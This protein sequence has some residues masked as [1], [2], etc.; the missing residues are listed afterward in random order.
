M[1]SYEIDELLKKLTLEEKIGMIHGQGIFHTKGVERL[2]LPPLWTSDGP[3][4]VRKELQDDNWNAKGTTEDFVSYLPSNSA[5]ACT[6]QPELAREMG[7]VLGE[8]ARGRGKDVILAPGINLMRSPLCGRNFEYMS[9]DPCLISKLAPALVQGIQEWD[10]AACVKH[11]AANNQETRRLDVDVQMEER[12]LRELYLPGF[13]ASVKEGKSLSVMGAYNR[14]RG[15]HC[16]HNHYLL[17]EVLRGEWGFDGVVI[18]DWGGVHDT[19][20]AAENGLDIEMSVTDCFDEYYMA[21]PLLEKVKRGELSEKLVDEKVRNILVLMDRL[22]MLDGK[23]KAGAYNTREHQEKLLECAREA[24]VL[25]KNEEN[26]LPLKLKGKKRLAVI[27]ENAVKQHAGGGGSGAIKALYELSPLMGLHM[28]LGGNVKID[29]APGYSSE[30][31]K[32][33]EKENWQSSSLED[34]AYKEAYQESYTKEEEERRAAL[35]QEAVKLAASCEDV[36]LFCGLNHEFDLEGQDRQ[37]LKLPYGQEELIE[38]VLEANPNTILVLISG[39]PVDLEAFA[40]KAKAILYSSYN[41]MEGGRALAEI[42]LGEVNPSGK[43]AFTFPKRLEDCP[44]HKLGEFPGGDQVFYREGV[45]VGY[46]YYETEG[47]PVR[48]CFGHG[49]SYT[50]FEYKDLKIHKKGEGFFVSLKVRNKGERKGKETVQLYVQAQG[51][52]V[53]RP[54]RELRAFEK[55]SLEPGEEKTVEFFL[56]RKAFSYY[57]EEKK[58]FFVPEDSYE[59]CVGSSVEDIRLREEVWAPSGKC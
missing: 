29:Y 56:E 30:K 14:F 8:E 9:E 40:D 54:L 53:R 50:E 13:E 43:L 46:R 25:L 51:R 57:D 12:T 55:L 52:K 34:R 1:K 45:F 21:D 4:G 3:M 47:L 31:E 7:K 15:E 35:R 37:S 26:L 39:S 23:R 6:F 41:G 18:S 38:A 44:A 20:Q 58:S 48:Y 2:G 16:C 22:H 11:F 42:L 59:I 32:T 24:A 33:E 5:L 10:T 36:L 17:R 19:D 49:L 28:R 27:G